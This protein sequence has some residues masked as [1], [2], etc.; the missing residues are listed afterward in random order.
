MAARYDR[1][2]I[3]DITK[4]DATGLSDHE[5]AQLDF[6][7]WL[8][9]PRDRPPFAWLHGFDACSLQFWREGAALLSELA[10][11]AHAILQRKEKEKQTLPAPRSHRQAGGWGGCS[12]CDATGA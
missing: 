2:E 5:R 10:S 9:R 12:P 11:H 6:L 8:D 7:K 3:L 4:P 1:F